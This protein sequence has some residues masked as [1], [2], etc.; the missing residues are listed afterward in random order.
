[1]STREVLVCDVCSAEC[2]KGGE[3]VPGGSTIR[4]NI[5]VG[6]SIIEVAARLTTKGEDVCVHCASDAMRKAALELSPSPLP[7]APPPV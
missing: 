7:K 1:V 4:A 2:V 6:G 3:S 5:T